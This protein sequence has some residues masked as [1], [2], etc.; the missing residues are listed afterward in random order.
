MVSIR[1][2]MVVK[3]ELNKLGLHYSSVDLGEVEIT[4][5]ITREQRQEFAAAIKE[6]G[7]ELMEDKKSILV[8]RIMTIIITTASILAG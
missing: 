8:E 6:T 4:G 1:C 3:T 7:L 5:D 2:I